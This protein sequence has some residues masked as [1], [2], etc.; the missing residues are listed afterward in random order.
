[1]SNSPGYP[2]GVKLNESLLAA[3]AAPNGAAAGGCVRSRPRSSGRPR[4]APA[5]PGRVGVGD[6]PSSRHALGLQRQV[7][8]RFFPG[9]APR[10]SRFPPLLQDLAEFCRSCRSTASPARPPKQSNT[11]KHEKTPL[12]ILAREAAGGPRLANAVRNR[13]Q[14]M[15]APSHYG[16]ISQIG[17]ALPPPRSPSPPPR[18][19]LP[20][21]CGSTFPRK[22]ATFSA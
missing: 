12:T 9:S 5:A 17:C 10:I 20:H 15:P 6:G 8:C 18:F 21:R 16:Q 3:G 22:N 4:R 2:L 11:L 1:M 19:S 14:T 7:F 13:N